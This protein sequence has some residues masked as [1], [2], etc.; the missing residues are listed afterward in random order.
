MT[1]GVFTVG[2]Y[3]VKVRSQIEEGFEIH[4][5]ETWKAKRNMQS[6]IVTYLLCNQISHLADSLVSLTLGNIHPRVLFDMSKTIK[7]I[8]VPTSTVPS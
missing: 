8:Q 7:T 2:T 3:T 5:V 6:V 4:G 1:R